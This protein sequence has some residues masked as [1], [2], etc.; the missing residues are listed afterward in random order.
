VNDP[1]LGEVTRYFRF[2]VP[3]SY[4]INTPLGLVVDYHGWTGDAHSQEKDSYF[5]G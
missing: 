2:H 3:K 5:T 1:E 4:D